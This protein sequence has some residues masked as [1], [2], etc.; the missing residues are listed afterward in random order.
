M[1]RF[2]PCLKTGV[3][4]HPGIN[5][6]V[7]IP[8]GQSTPEESDNLCNHLTRGHGIAFYAGGVAFVVEFPDNG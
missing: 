8:F 6:F 2:I 7:P 5:L 4:S 3:F 1:G